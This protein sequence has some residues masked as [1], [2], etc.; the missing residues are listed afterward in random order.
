MLFTGYR[1]T[2]LASALSFPGLNPK[3][4]PHLDHRL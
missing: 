4:Y 3:D 2:P 1:R